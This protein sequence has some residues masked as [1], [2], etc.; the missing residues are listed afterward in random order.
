MSARAR[1]VRSSPRCSACSSWRRRS[2]TPAR[3]AA[4]RP[5]SIATA[6]RM[7]ASSRTASAARNAG[8]TRHVAGARATRRSCPRSSFLRRAARSST[9]ARSASARSPPRRAPRTPP[10]STTKRPP[11]PTECDFCQ[12]APPA[13]PPASVFAEAGVIGEGG[14]TP[15][16][17]RR[18]RGCTGVARRRVGAACAR[19][20]RLRH[21]PPMVAAPAIS[22]T[23]A[24]SASRAPRAHGSRA[25]RGTSQRHPKGAF[26]E[27]VRA[28]F[29]DEEPRFFEASQATQEGARRYLANLPDGPHAA[30]ALALLTA[31]GSNMQDAELRDIARR[32]RYDDAK[33]ESA[34]VQRRAVGEAILGA[35]GVLLDEEVYGVPR[36]EGPPALRALMT[37]RTGVDVGHGAASS[38]RGPL[39]PPPH[40]ARAR[41]APLHARGHARRAGRRR[42]R[43]DA[44]KAPTCSCCGPRPIRS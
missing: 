21:V 40:A 26:A 3:A 41:V 6:T 2:A 29:D 22:R 44:S 9:T 15:M 23:I 12:V 17:A 4:R 42:R 25:R 16:E 37:G 36:A 13:P 7:R 43:R 8:S 34:A 24:R 20:R 18:E 1:V 31:L 30:A 32:V 33:L 14:T 35:V 11:T 39:L 5:T 28:A 10:T 27:E 19:I 38:R